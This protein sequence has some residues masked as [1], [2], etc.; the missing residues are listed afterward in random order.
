MSPAI[1]FN[2]DQFKIVSSSNGLKNCTAVEHQLRM[3]SVEYQDLGTV[4][5]LYDV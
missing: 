2:L 5:C 4:M 3:L 1:C